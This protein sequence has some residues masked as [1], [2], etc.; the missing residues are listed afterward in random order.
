MNISPI[1]TE[2]DYDAALDEVSELVDATPGTDDGDRLEVLVTLIQAYEDRHHP[3]TAPDP[4]EAL[5][6]FM[7]SRGISRRELEPFVGSRG[8]VSEILNRRRPLTLEMIRRLHTGLG[9]DAD[10]LIQPYT[11]QVQ[12]AC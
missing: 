2:S 12:A 6:Y 8:R 1:R 9:I 7:E 10:V 4:I 3:I 5:E 11:L